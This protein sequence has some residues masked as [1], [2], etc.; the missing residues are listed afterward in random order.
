MGYIFNI[1]HCKKVGYKSENINTTYGLK[2]AG[3]ADLL[4]HW[5]VNV[6]K[7]SEVLEV[8]MGSAIGLKVSN[9]LEE[10]VESVIGPRGSEVLE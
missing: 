2:T 8:E 5:S 3:T 7:G 9:V 6:L 10:D 1:P 4:C